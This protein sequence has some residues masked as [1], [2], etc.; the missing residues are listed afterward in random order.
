MIE[1]MGEK[2]KIG[3]MCMSSQRKK[4]Q[5][6]PREKE[7]EHGGLGCALFCLCWCM[8]GRTISKQKRRKR[9]EASLISMSF[10]TFLVVVVIFAWLRFCDE[11]RGRRDD[12]TDR[13]EG[14][15]LALRSCLP[16]RS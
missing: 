15:V 1:R 16:G 11:R 3:Y 9:D 5:Q 10:G 14:A 8:C 12:W 4:R 6:A 2:I 13:E 7:E